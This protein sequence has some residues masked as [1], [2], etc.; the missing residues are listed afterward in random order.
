M[1]VYKMMTGIDIQS[2]FQGLEMLHMSGHR[3]KVRERDFSENKHESLNDWKL[4]KCN[5]YFIALNTFCLVVLLGK[6]QVYTVN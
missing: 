1:H 5:F 6:T 2:P 3:F 4:S